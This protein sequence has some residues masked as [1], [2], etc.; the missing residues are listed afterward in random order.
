MKSQ[1]AMLHPFSFNSFL[2]EADMKQIRENQ[3]EKY[4]MTDL[5]KPSLDQ[6]VLLISPIRVDFGKKRK[7]DKQW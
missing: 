6:A 5:L 2:Y 4:L 7:I 3:K 1:D